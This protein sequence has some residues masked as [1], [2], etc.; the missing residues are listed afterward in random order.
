M[1]DLVFNPR[2]LG[3]YRVLRL[4]EAY[5]LAARAH[6]GQTRKDGTTPYIYHPSRVANSVIAYGGTEP[7]VIAA[8]WHDIAEDCGNEWY[9]KMQKCLDRLAYSVY[10]T[11]RIID[12]VKSL[13]KNPNLKNRAEKNKD[14]L[15]RCMMAGTE[16]IKL[17]DRLDNV[18]DSACMTNAFIKVYFEETDDMLE[19][20]LCSGR[21]LDSTDSDAYAMLTLVLEQTRK[22]RGIS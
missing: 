15:E 10:T 18:R 21:S 8:L 20:F 6:E 4:M 17:C 3:K 14:A 12:M 5:N 22:S 16:R 11:W 2:G 7:E 19:T 9:P 1:T 13:T